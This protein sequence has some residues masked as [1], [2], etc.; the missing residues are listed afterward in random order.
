MNIYRIIKVII[1]LLTVIILSCSSSDSSD[2]N[3]TIKGQINL[4][5]HGN[6]AGIT[7]AL[8]QLAQADTTLNRIRNEYS[9]IGVALVQ[10]AIFD[11][12]QQ[13]PVKT[14][15]T[16]NN[17]F[18]TLDGV[19]PGQYNLVLLKEG[20]ST[21]YFY[22][23]QIT[24]GDNN[25]FSENKGMTIMKAMVNVPAVI[26]SPYVFQSG[27]QYNFN[28]N[29]VITAS[30]NVESGAKLCIAPGKK[31]DV[32]DNFNVIAQNNE[33]WYCT[34]SHQMNQINQSGVID[35]MNYF[36]RI[37]FTSNGTIHIKNAVVSQS[38]SGLNVMSHSS[39]I[40]ES[41][42]RINDNAMAIHGGNTEV[43]KCI[44]SDSKERA[45]Y[46][47]HNQNYNQ[48]NLNNHNNIFIRYNVANEIIQLDTNLN[49][50]Y[51]VSGKT[52]ISLYR[53]STSTI[54]YNNFWKNEDSVELK[55]AFSEIKRNKFF[56]ND[57]SD[58]CFNV[59]SQVSS[60]TVHYN[61]F[62]D[63]SHYLLRLTPL[64]G[65]QCV[66]N[67]IDASNNYFK[68]SDINAQLYDKNDDDRILYEF[69]TT[70]RSAQPISNCGIQL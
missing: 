40:E 21:T 1:L 32:Y 25:L 42:F 67:N 24:S 17:G 50:N 12:R 18:F 20:W 14:V 2:P 48:N 38:R 63:T 49:N 57:F 19:I 7:V 26:N 37:N 27:V 10:K 34:S 22:Q 9:N 39:I 23:L 29:T 69:L 51:F 28:Q 36:E 62:Y 47:I 56:N 65:A 43:K 13:M 45:L 4:E 53:N 70:P 64:N 68:N 8:Y 44:F 60:G 11:H 31:V 55:G 16:D 46:V 54:E 59:G 61:N 41:I 58:I 6:H 33:Y 35:S 15:Q 66:D 3:A 5:A 52:G 30:V